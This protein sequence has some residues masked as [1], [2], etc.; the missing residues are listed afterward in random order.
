[1]PLSLKVH[2]YQRIPGTTMVRLQKV[3][4]YIRLCEGAGPPIYLQDGQAWSEGGADPLDVAT[5]P[6]WFRT[7]LARLTPAARA[8]VG[9]RLP[10][11]PPLPE[12]APALTQTPRRGPRLGRPRGE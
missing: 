3:T 5:L 10:D 6:E 9:W 12:P 8:E 11:D 2:H 4:P 1:M 7:G